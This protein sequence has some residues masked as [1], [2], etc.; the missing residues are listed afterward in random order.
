MHKQMA[1]IYHFQ[2]DGDARTEDACK[3]RGLRVDD[4]LGY[5]CTCNNLFSGANCLLGEKYRLQTNYS[6]SRNTHGIHRRVH[7]V[8]VTNRVRI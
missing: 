8:P 5:E 6:N 1:C 4:G 2:S 3:N 7:R